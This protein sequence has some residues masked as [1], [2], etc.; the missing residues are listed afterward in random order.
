MSKINFIEYLT[1]FARQTK[2][3]F[4]G[5]IRGRLLPLSSSSIKLYLRE[6]DNLYS[7]KLTEVSIEN[8][9]PEISASC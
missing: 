6:V 4:S 8:S 7:E 1:N 5:G 3:Q 2:H 9:K